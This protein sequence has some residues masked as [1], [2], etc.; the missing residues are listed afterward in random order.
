MKNKINTSNKALSNNINYLSWYEFWH[1]RKAAALAAE[2]KYNKNIIDANSNQDD[3]EAAMT[4]KLSLMEKKFEEKKLETIKMI[5]ITVV[6]A[7]VAFVL[8]KYV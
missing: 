8:V 5:T 2:E 3:L 4:Y 1:P 6:F 7:V